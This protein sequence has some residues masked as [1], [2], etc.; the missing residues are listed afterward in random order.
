MSMSSTIVSAVNKAFTSLGDLVG[1]LTVRHHAENYSPS[2]NALIKT[3][4][5]TVVKGIV[6][7]YESEGNDGV[8]S[9]DRRIYIQHQEGLLIEIGDDIV[10][11]D[12]IIYA[13]KEPKQIKPSTVILLWDIR[14]RA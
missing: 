1:D 12:G 13:V 7:E 14:G 11:P 10:D 9:E 4:T 3:T 2:T 6:G 5:E 8:Q